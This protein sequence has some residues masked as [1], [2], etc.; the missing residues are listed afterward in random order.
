MEPA[1]PDLATPAPGASAGPTWRT[2]LEPRPVALF[3][4]VTLFIWGN[5]IWLAWTNPDDTVAEKLVWSTPIT[6]FVLAALVIG[7]LLL[8][9]ADRRSPGFVRGVTAFAAGTTLYWAVRIP[10]ILLADHPVGFKVVHAV[11][12]AVS[13]ALAVAAWRSVRSSRA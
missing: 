5:R 3:C 10:M 9:G 12:A 1:S 7:G 11:L 6:L 8:T 13:I 2:R 4:A